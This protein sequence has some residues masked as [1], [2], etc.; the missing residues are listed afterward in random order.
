MLPVSI[1]NASHIAIRDALGKL[2][3]CIAVINKAEYGDSVAQKEGGCDDDQ[4]QREK[5]WGSQL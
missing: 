4:E 2:L 5:L 1:P 3:S